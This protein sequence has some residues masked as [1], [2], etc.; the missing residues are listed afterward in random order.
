MFRIEKDIE[1]MILSLAKVSGSLDQWL[2]SEEPPK[3]M[4]MLTWTP[5]L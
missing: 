4:L 3:L 2:S 5:I 1:I